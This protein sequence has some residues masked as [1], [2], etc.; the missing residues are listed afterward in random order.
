MSFPVAIRDSDYG[1]LGFFG[2]GLDPRF[3][4]MALS[5]ALGRNKSPGMHR[6]LC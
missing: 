1:Y 5:H 4:G 3:R 6:L 2:R